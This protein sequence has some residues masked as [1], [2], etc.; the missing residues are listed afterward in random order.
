MAHKKKRRPAATQW[1]IGYCRKS[2]D[3]E[4][5]QVNSLPDQGVMITNYYARL[6]DA[7]R[8][9]PLRI[10]QEAQSAYH[11]GRAV[12]GDILRM[13]DGGEVRGVIVVHPNRVSR[14]H[15]DSGAFVQ[16]LV[17]GTIPSLDTTS[18]KRY[19]GADSNDIFM[20]TLEGA[21]S[22][23]DSRDKGDR[24]LQAMR[25]RAT[26]GK[27]MG[28]VRIGYKSVYRPDGT[29]I[30]EPDPAT[31]P[32]IR[33]LFEMAGMGTYSVRSLVAE[34]D[35]MGLRSKKGNKFWVSNLHAI[36]RDPLYKGM[37]RFDGIIARG[38]H[39]PIV[40]E[41]LWEQ[42]Q[43]LLRGRRTDTGRAKDPGLRELFVFGNL[44]RCPGCSRSLCP[45]R[46]K[47]KY[48]YYECKNPRRHCGVLVPQPALVEQLPPLLQSVTLDK[49]SLDAVRA[50]LLAQHKARSGN[51]AESRQAG[52][53]EYQKV[54]KEIGDIFTR[55]TEAE[56]LGVLDVVDRRL[57]ELRRR[58]EELQAAMQPGTEMDESWIDKA[59]KS[60]M[61]I[62]LLREAII[63][64][65]RHSRE[66]AMKALASNYT[67]DGKKLIPKLR[68]PFRQ[69]AERR[70]VQEWCTTLYD[71]RTEIV[72]TCDLLQSA[73]AILKQPS[74]FRPELKMSSIPATRG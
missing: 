63:F 11:P 34:A 17:E 37:I 23:K 40:E 67:V 22:W 24:I 42:V 51:D 47:G 18:G 4:D 65:S 58:R 14:N 7:E 53:A 35:R 68:S 44:I 61:L 38:R 9:H 25:M 36:L 48:V 16:R 27:H 56:E 45:Y 28:L 20:L 60:F 3:S 21:M 15:A 41:E 74:P 71:V 50:R 43:D 2:T 46:V 52:Q 49:G 64:G 54:V 69:C 26:E 8:R 5:K 19:T 59:V 12:F 10:L 73:Y 57:A 66:M 31:A 72:Q 13:A 6:P 1:W 30:L 55:R 33:R 32:Q 29:P 70:G 62:E 39:E